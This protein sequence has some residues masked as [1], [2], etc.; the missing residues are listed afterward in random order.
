MKTD[1]LTFYSSHGVMTDPGPFASLLDVLPHDIPSLCAIVQG[2]LVH[3]L[4]T[5]LYSVELTSVQRKEVNI[6]PVR[7]MLRLMQSLDDRPLTEARP[8]D[9]RVVGN[10]RDHAVLFCSFLRQQGVPA[11]VRV[12]FA[13]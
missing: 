5:G 2:L 7:E 12:G 4:T 8:T 13:T 3:P 9:E 6:R 1:F 11:R 10:C